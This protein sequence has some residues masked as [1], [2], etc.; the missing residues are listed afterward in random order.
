[1]KFRSSMT[2]FELVAADPEPFSQV[3]NE[4]YSGDRD[5]ETLRLLRRR[6]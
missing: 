4:Y 6:G 2:L 5:P 3:L 1:M